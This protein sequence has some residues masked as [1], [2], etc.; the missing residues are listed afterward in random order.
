MQITAQKL[1]SALQGVIN[2]FENQH[3]S[4]LS[5][6]EIADISN[7]GYGTIRTIKN[8]SLKN[9]SIKKALEISIRLNGPSKLE[10]LLGT[11]EDKNE[12]VQLYAKKFSHLFKYNM[13]PKDQEDLFSNK[14]FAVILWSTFGNDHITLDEIRYRWG[15]EGID[16]INFLVDVGMVKVEQG[17]A[18]GITENAGFGIESAYKQ[19]NIGLSLYDLNRSNKD[20]NWISFQTESVNDKFIKNFREKLRELFNEF[21]EKS[22]LKSNKG[23]K[24]IFFN[25]TLDKYMEDLK[26]IK[27]TSL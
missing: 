2:S 16:K 11:L 24:R 26:D 14:D 7:S 1:V 15:Q 27:G 20:E 23:S 13:F 5:I 17:I 3:H 22:Q 4:K 25:M 6:Q 18:K 12:N 8:G 19:S 9:I 10:D 21:E